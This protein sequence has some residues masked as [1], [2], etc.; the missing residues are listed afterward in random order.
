MQITHAETKSK[1]TMDKSTYIAEWLN[2]SQPPK[3]GEYLQTLKD[4]MSN[5]EIFPP[6]ISF[7]GN[8]LTALTEAAEM[9]IWQY[10]AGNEIKAMIVTN[11]APQIRIPNHSNNGTP[12]KR[13]NSSTKTTP[14]KRNVDSIKQ[15]SQKSKHVRFICEIC[16]FSCLNKTTLKEHIDEVHAKRDGLEDN[17]NKAKG[18][19]QNQGEH[20]KKQRWLKRKRRVNFFSPS[21]RKIEGRYFKGHTP[22]IQG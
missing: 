16:E 22:S 8:A 2:T 1:K 10:L 17:Y 14:V 21:Y 5:P 15:E 3:T 4:I 13:T 18:S 12:R 11:E 19:C 7:Q 20:D 9:Y 6:G